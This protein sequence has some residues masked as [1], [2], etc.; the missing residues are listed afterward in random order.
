M[1]SAMRQTLL[2][3]MEIRAL[4]VI[5]MRLAV[6]RNGYECGSIITCQ[7]SGARAIFPKCLPEATKLCYTSHGSCC[8]APRRSVYAM[9]QPVPKLAAP[10]H[11]TRVGSRHSRD[12]MVPRMVT[13]L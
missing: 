6:S 3:V 5:G 9:I 2:L 4:T 13:S 11:G 12:R 7:R 8:R 1:I 10:S